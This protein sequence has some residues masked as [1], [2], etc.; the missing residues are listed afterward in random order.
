MNWYGNTGMF[1]MA[2]EEWLGASTVTGWR[3]SLGLQV[4][5][6]KRSSHRR[7]RRIRIVRGDGEVQ[8]LVVHNPPF[9]A[10]QSKFVSENLPAYPAC[11]IFYAR[12]FV[13]VDK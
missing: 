2:E 13:D 4:V 12:L 8:D 11:D 6:G 1:T 9:F 5:L 7:R 10:S 3:S